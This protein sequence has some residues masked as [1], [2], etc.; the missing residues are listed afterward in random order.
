MIAVILKDINEVQLVETP[1]VRARARALAERELD[2]AHAAVVTL[3]AD[4]R[5]RQRLMPPSGKPAGGVSIIVFSLIPAVIVAAVGAGAVTLV[6]RAHF[7]P[8][9]LGIAAVTGVLCGVTIIANNQKKLAALSSQQHDEQDRIRAA[10]TFAH[11]IES[12]VAHRSKA[13]VN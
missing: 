8:W 4:S 1:E 6:S 5:N 9:F 10:E 3:K 2:Q 7:M 11:G 13:L 12:R